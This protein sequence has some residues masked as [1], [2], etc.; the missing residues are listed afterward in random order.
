MDTYR[1]KA[2]ALPVDKAKFQAAE[3][4]VMST[5]NPMQQLILLKSPVAERLVMAIGNNPEKLDAISK[6]TDP[7]DLAMELG[8]IERQLT[9]TKQ[10][11]SAP[12]PDRPLSGVNSGPADT[13]LERLEEEAMRTGS[14]TKVVAYKKQKAS[15][16]K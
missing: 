6:L 16:T 11:K 10:T 13:A 4:E 3:N 8:R 1:A 9:S 5:F 7:I 14:R 12:Q 2:A 15:A